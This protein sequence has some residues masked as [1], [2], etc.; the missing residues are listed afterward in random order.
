MLDDYEIYE[1][2]GSVKPDKNASVRNFT[3]KIN[4]RFYEAM[5][6]SRLVG[7]TSILTG[8]LA[9]GSPFPV[10]M[11]GNSVHWEFTLRSYGR[12]GRNDY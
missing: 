8:S 4:V 11:E 2:L 10:N 3:S 1:R 6:K 12:G 5:L 9:L 7:G